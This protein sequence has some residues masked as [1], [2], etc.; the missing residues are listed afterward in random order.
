[1]RRFV[2]TPPFKEC[3]PTGLACDFN[4]THTLFQVRCIS[5]GFEKE[6]PGG[7]QTPKTLARC[8]CQFLGWLPYPLD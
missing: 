6:V 7:A 1:M 3:T 4:S 8:Q 2:T 5:S